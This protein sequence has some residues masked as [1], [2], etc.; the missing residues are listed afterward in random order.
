MCCW[1]QQCSVGRY[2]LFANVTITLFMSFTPAVVLL[3]AVHTTCLF[4]FWKRYV[5]DTEFYNIKQEN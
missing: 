5:A 2:L 4:V 1:P 3:A